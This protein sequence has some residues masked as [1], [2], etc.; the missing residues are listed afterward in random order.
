MSIDTSMTLTHLDRAE[1]WSNDLKETTKDVLMAQ[2]YVDWMT[3]FPDGSQFT[4]PSIG[5]LEANDYSENEAVKYQSLDTGEFTFNITEYV[6]SG[7][8]ITRKAQQDSFYASQLMAGFLP[9][10]QR[11]LDERLEADIYRQGQPGVAGGQTVANSNSI[12]GAPHRW[13][14]SGTLNTKKVIALEDYAKVVHSFK[15]A[16]IP[17]SG[18][19]AIVDPSNEFY[20]NTLSNIVNVSNN[21][22][23]EGVITEGLGNDLKFTKNIYGIDIYTSN[24]L[25]L[26]GSGQTGSSE[27]ISGVASGAN[28]VCNVFFSATS[29]LLPIKGAYRQLPQVD[30]KFNQDFQRDEFVVTARY[31]LKLFRP[32]NFITILSDPSAVS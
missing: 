14:G 7:L 12:N 5:D 3:E 13:V 24:R 31:G 18:L 21:P 16:N 8:Y 17:T 27:T 25:A 19:V 26:C 22:K 30:T 11:A 1:I 28:A 6:Q 2:K 32:E 29:D 9:K 20:L 23:W 10:M 4:I 15:K